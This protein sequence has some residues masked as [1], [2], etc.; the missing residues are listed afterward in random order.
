MTETEIE[1]YESE[2][3]TQSSPRLKARIRQRHGETEQSWTDAAGTGREVTE[4]VVRDSTTYQGGTLDEVTVTATKS[5]G[6]W[7]RVRAGLAITVA[8]IIPAAAGWVI[9]KHQKRKTI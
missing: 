6:L 9:Y 2:P 4:T 8:I 5:P 7:D 3:D 1:I